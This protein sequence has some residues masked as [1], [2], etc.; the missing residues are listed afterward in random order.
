[1]I[2]LPLRTP[3]SIPP[4]R[5]IDRAIPIPPGPEPA[6]RYGLI[7]VHW[8]IK[9]KARQDR[10]PS[11]PMRGPLASL[12]LDGSHHPSARGSLGTSRPAAAARPWR[13][14]EA[15]PQ[16]APIILTAFGHGNRVEV[17]YALRTPCL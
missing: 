7:F 16:G 1:M 13:Q 9:S 11:E 8:Q 3:A 2:R 10:R 14:S 17:A 15:L 4:R 6:N 5:P 12:A